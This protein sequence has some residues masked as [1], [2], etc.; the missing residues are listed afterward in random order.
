[1]QRFRLPT[2]LLAWAAAA[3]VLPV[4]HAQESSRPAVTVAVVASKDITPS[5]SF[6]GRIE[7]I[8]SVDLRARVQG[9]LDQRL[10]EEGADVEKG[11]LLF[12]IEKAPYAAEIETIRAS[13]ARAQAS[14]D[15]A[16][17][18]RRRQEALVK[19]QAVAQAVLDQAVAKAAEARADLQRQQA[20]LTKAELSL[21]YTD[22][23]SPIAGRIGRAA[24]S[25]GDFVEPASGTLATV[26]SQDPI[27]VTFPVTQ[28]QLLEVRKASAA[29]GTDPG[30]ITIGARLA[31]G[32]LYAHKGRLNFVD[33]RVDPGTDTVQVR[34]TLPNPDRLLVD[35]QLVTAV[36]ET[37]R[38]EAALV[39]PQAAVQIDQ[40]G[41][42]VL[43]VDGEQKVQVQR[44][45]IKGE[46]DGLYVVADGLKEGDRVITEGLQK[47]RPGMAV[48]AAPATT[49]AAG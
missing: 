30:S 4:A 5:V 12:V 34:A 21:S 1:M 13:I 16:E 39:I 32:S 35:G 45:T 42:Y 33:V 31:D 38:P 49:A 23:R 17:I 40:A 9:F 14:L 24:F 48:D 2:W 27:Y 36:A 18:E 28:R 19:K 44:I 20:N 11:D 25:V 47:V 15:L 10:F 29:G 43:R 26:V 3:A 6:T 8:D 22:I 37:A 7:A 41:R 46:Q